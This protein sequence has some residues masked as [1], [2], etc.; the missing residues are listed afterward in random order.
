MQKLNEFVLLEPICCTSMSIV[1]WSM[2]RSTHKNHTKQLSACWLTWRIWTRCET[3]VGEIFSNTSTFKFIAQ[4]YIHIY[5]QYICSS[6]FTVCQYLCLD[7]L[8]NLLRYESYKQTIKKQPAS[9]N[10]LWVCQHRKH[11]ASQSFTPFLVSQY[12]HFL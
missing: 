12:T 10:I 11:P 9:N 8:R 6:F 5:I 7:L 2:N 3:W 1:L 4:N